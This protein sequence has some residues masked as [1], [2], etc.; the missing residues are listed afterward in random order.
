[1]ASRNIQTRPIYPDLDT[2]PHLNCDE[3]FPNTRIFGK[4]GLV[5]PCG[6]DQPLENVSR[7][8]EVLCSIGERL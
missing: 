5:L 2:A 8:I 4:Q 3:D 7:V 1:L 6:P